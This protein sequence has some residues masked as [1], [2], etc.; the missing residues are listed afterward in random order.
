MVDGDLSVQGNLYAHACITTVTASTTLVTAQS[1]VVLVSNAAAATI[2]LPAAVSA[3]GL[4]FTIKR[5]TA[6]AVTVASAGGTI[7]GA[8]TLALAAQYDFITVISDGSNWYI[9]GR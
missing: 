4:T 2:T 7:D 6:N 9:T 1:G 8:A 5:L 3:T